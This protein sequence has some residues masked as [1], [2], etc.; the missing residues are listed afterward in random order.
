MRRGGE[1]I[2]SFRAEKDLDETNGSDGPVDPEV[3]EEDEGHRP[4]NKPVETLRADQ[5]GE[6][7]PARKTTSRLQPIFGLS[8]VC[9]GVAL[10]TT[11][12]P[13]PIGVNTGRNGTQC[14]DTAALML[15]FE[16]AAALMLLFERARIV[17]TL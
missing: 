9:L 5:Y 10:V 1:H 6:N 12:S 7:T 4:K 2:D 11:F 3:S 13:P 16:R 8:L 14:A 17:R 15:L